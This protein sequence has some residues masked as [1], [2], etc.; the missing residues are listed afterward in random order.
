[1]STVIKPIASRYVDKYT[2]KRKIV[3]VDNMDR[4]NGMAIFLEVV[5]QDGRVFLYID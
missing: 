3:A 4:L 5:N 1:M 2:I